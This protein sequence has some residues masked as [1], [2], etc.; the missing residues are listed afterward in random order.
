MFGLIEVVLLL[1]Q[2]VPVVSRSATLP[3]PPVPREHIDSWRARE[4]GC[5]PGKDMWQMDTTPGGPEPMLGYRCN[6]IDGGQ[7]DEV[8]PLAPHVEQHVAS[9]PLTTKFGS[10]HKGRG[11]PAVAQH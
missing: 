4:I 7:R 8:Q 3:S 2:G 10:S 5:R 1:Y 6:S 11:R 9:M